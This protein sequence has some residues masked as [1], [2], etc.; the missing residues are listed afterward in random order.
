MTT[1][2][3]IGYAA[4]GCTLCSLLPQI[5]KVYRTKRAEDISMGMLHLLFSGALL[6]AIYGILLQEFPIVL[7]NAIYL[8]LLVYQIHLKRKHSQ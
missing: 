2:T 8:I 6:W 1:E 7:F 5:V 3:A 4:G